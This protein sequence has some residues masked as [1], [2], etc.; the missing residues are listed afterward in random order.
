[1]RGA[2]FAGMLL[3]FESTILVSANV[4]PLQAQLRIITGEEQMRFITGA[5]RRKSEFSP[6][7]LRTPLFKGTDSSRIFPLIN[8]MRARLVSDA[9]WLRF[10]CAENDRHALVFSAAVRSFIMA[11]NIIFPRIV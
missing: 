6:S 1:M 5:A 9:L 2:L 8:E 7:F 3:K 4:D 11:R 10:A